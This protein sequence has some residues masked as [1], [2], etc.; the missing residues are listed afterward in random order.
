MIKLPKISV[1]TTRFQQGLIFFSVLY[2]T[3]LLFIQYKQSYFSEDLIQLKKISSKEKRLASNV[4]VGLHIYN[5]PRFNFYKNAFIMDGTVFFK[6]PI[7]SESLDTIEKFNFQNGEILS[8]SDPLVQIIHGDVMIR[9]HIV[10]KLSTNL[11][12]KNFP[13]SDHKLTVILQNTTV[14]PYELYFTSDTDSFG[15][16]KDLLS[17]N[18]KPETIYVDYGYLKS[19]TYREYTAFQAIFPSVAFTI[20]FKNTDL[21]HFII[22][23][24]PLFLLFLIIFTSLLTG[25]ESIHIRFPIVASVIPILA[26]HSLVIES[27]SPPGSHMTKIDQTYLTII[28]LSLIILLFQ[29]YVG[30][31]IKGLTDSGDRF[32]EKR[33][34]RLKKIN[35]FVIIF[36]LAVLIISVSYS[37]FT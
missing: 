31:T 2:L 6:F 10:V 32:V 8:K 11:N 25:V 35:D 16:S 28:T 37:T 4:E 7:G 12:Y 27:V 14:S 21:R 5:F 29:S 26:L 19:A 13:V 33:K 18:W 15:L 22:L 20:D 3:T 1:H 30:L 9:Y 17:G 34:E 36:V 24:L 23:Y